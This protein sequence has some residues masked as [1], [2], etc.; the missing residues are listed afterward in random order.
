MRRWSRIHFHMHTT[1]WSSRLSGLVV[2]L[3]RHRPGKQNVSTTPGVSLTKTLGGR[4][5]GASC[6]LLLL[7]DGSNAE[8]CAVGRVMGLVHMWDREV[9]WSVYGSADQ[10]SYVSLTYGHER[11][12][13]LVWSPHMNRSWCIT[14][15]STFRRLDELAFHFNIVHD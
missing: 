4:S 11:T 15:V 9:M 5:P 2:Q 10:S 6:P 1:H 13:Q 3:V 7:W 14:G 12:R 8:N